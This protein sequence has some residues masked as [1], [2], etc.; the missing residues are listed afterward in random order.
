MDKFLSIPVTNEGNQLV[1][2][3]GVKAI[4]VGDAAGANDATNT[5]LFYQSGKVVTITHA[6]VGAATA[7]NSATQF[8]TWLQDNMISALGTDWTNVVNSVEPKYA[9]S[10]IVIATY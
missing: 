1:P 9:V 5:S 7:S 6:T 3:T 4:N 2:M 10:G 8:R